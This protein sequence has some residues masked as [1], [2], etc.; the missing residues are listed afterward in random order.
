M[1][2]RVTISKRVLS[3]GVGSVVTALLVAIPMASSTGAGATSLPSAAALEPAQGQYVAI[4]P[5]EIFDTRNGLGGAPSIISAGQSINNIQVAGFTPSGWTSPAIPTTGVTAVFV[6]LQVLSTSS[7]GYLTDYEADITN[8]GQ[9]SVSYGGGLAE[10]GSDVVTIAPPGTTNAGDMA[11]T[12][13]GYGNIALAIQ[14]E[15]YFTDGSQSVA[16][17]TFIAVP[18][19]QL[20]GNTSIPAGQSTTL[21]VIDDAVTAGAVSS[22]DMSNIDTLALEIGTINPTGYGYITLTGG[23][24]TCQGTPPNGTYSN[25]TSILRQMT[26]QPSE[27]NRLTDFIP[28]ETSA[29]GSQYGNGSITITNYG[30]VAVTIQVKLQG[31]FIS[32]LTTDLAGESFQPLASGPQRVC[33]TRNYPAICQDQNG[34]YFTG[35]VAAYTSINVQETGL[36]GIPAGASYVADE[37]DA[38]N[39]T[40]TGWLTVSPYSPTGQDQSTQPVV[41]FSSTYDGA[42]VSFQAAVVSQTSSSGVITIYNDSPGSVNIVVSARGYWLGATAP[43][44]PNDVNSQLTGSTATLTWGQPADG[45]APIVTYTVKDTTTNST[46][47]V[48]GDVTTASVP[49]SSSSDLLTVAATNAVDI[50][51]A[52]APIQAD[53]SQPGGSNAP[54]WP[55]VIQGK[56]LPPPASSQVVPPGLGVSLSEVGNGTNDVSSD[57]P[58]VGTAQTTQNG[59]WTYQISSFDSLPAQA[60]ADATNNA[61]WLNLNVDTTAFGSVSGTTFGEIASGTLAV[62]VGT[63]S[64]T[65]V[66]ATYSLTTTLQSAEPVQYT[67][68]STDYQPAVSSM[69]VGDGTSLNSTYAT[70]MSPAVAADAITNP[71]LKTT[72]NPSV[73]DPA[74]GT[75]M[76]LTNA[77]VT[78]SVPDGNVV[79]TDY[80]PGEFSQQCSQ[81]F[82]NSSYRQGSPY[83]YAWEVAY[84][85][86]AIPNTT[87]FG[88]VPTALIDA[89]P[90]DGVNVTIQH[91]HTAS[92]QLGLSLNYGSVFTASGSV[93]LGYTNTSSNGY[94]IGQTS[95]TV[96]G[97]KAQ[98]HQD[99]VTL[100]C[101]V[102]AP[103][104]PTGPIVATDLIPKWLDPSAFKIAFTQWDTSN[105]NCGNTTD[106]TLCTK[107]SGCNASNNQC[108]DA[109]TTGNSGGVPTWGYS[110]SHCPAI[111][112]SVTHGEVGT[113]FTPTDAERASYLCDG[114]SAQQA[115]AYFDW[116][117]GNGNESLRWPGD[118]FSK[119]RDDSFAVS[120]GFTVFGFGPTVTSSWDESMSEALNFGYTNPANGDYYPN[121]CR[122][123][124]GSTTHNGISYPNSEK[125]WFW[126]YGDGNSLHN[127]NFNNWWTC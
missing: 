103:A 20:V 112:T 82:N 64:P 13:N 28:P 108:Q 127:E 124:A 16:N 66:P 81:A 24:S 79:D 93:T 1:S 10:S 117:G 119:S 85:Y 114:E 67:P 97:L 44:S 5:V 118:N 40:S 105:D 87:A 90:G 23:N 113:N 102:V 48:D 75:T 57:T 72:L 43:D 84:S 30:A 8:P 42:N 95:H 47:V 122:T 74:G 63:S 59:A 123:A 18:S 76:D 45:G 120:G 41:N 99:S 125:H 86:K 65:T 3:I 80:N 88:Y 33:D 109:D 94:Q 26:F 11:V 73:A 96:F 19:V 104:L 68:T 91:S 37:I 34:S 58:I 89:G 70:A 51:A 21:P 98:F 83:D 56:V 77:I 115:A 22:A 106:Q 52:S 61:G 55:I 14:V 53:G 9:A 111:P 49:V 4:N 6:N 17:D 29:C 2:S 101:D 78:S 100:H 39:P 126:V 92:L 71:S 36:D 25:T 32:P 107:Y 110:Q 62:F 46:T 50:G 7:S 60:Q 38:V 54:T 121:G 35:S 116:N 27:K 12:A 31:Y 69:A 15:G